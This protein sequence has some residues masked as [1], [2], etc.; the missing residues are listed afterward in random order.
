MSV[1]V[2]ALCWR[3]RLPVVDKL[4]LLRLA[5]YADHDGSSIY[6]AVATVASDCGVS[7]R[8]VQYILKK[9]TND[10]ILILVGNA[11]GGRGKTR[12]YAMDLERLSALMAPSDETVQTPQRVQTVQSVCTLSPI[13][14]QSVCAVSEATQTAQTPQRVQ[15]ETEKGANLMHPTRQESVKESKKE[16]P[17]PPAVGSDE[18]SSA[19]PALFDGFVSEPETPAPEKVKSSRRAKREKTVRYTDSQLKPFLKKFEAAYPPSD[20]K[21]VFDTAFRTIER[22]VNASKGAVDPEALVAAATRYHQSQ[23]GKG[24]VGTQWIKKPNNWLN[25]GEW[26]AYDGVHPF[27]DQTPNRSELYV[28]TYGE[29]TVEEIKRRRAAIGPYV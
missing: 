10:G 3:I 23:S 5:D 21:H 2:S 12:H 24:K 9:F 17:L 13:T 15:D 19:E 7:E 14:V 11:T 26:K 29:E 20:E 25:S 28:L 16:S 18:T 22:L 6:P 4:I 8:A 27:P 1:K